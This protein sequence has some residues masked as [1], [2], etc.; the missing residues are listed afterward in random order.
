MIEDADD[1]ATQEVGGF[2]RSR[3]TPEGSPLLDFDFR[4]HQNA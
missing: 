4:F 2:G 1:L 3:W